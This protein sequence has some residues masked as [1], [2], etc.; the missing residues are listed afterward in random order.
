MLSTTET[1]TDD[2]KHEH[3]DGGDSASV[4]VEDEVL[5]FIDLIEADT[6]TRGSNILYIDSQHDVIDLADIGHTNN[7]ETGHSTEEED[8]QYDGLNI[9]ESDNIGLVQETNM[10]EVNHENMASDAVNPGTR[11]HTN[12]SEEVDYTDSELGQS[13]SL[14]METN[15]D[16]LEEQAAYDVIEVDREFKE[17]D[18]I[19]HKKE[20]HFKD[21]AS[22]VGETGKDTPA[23]A[24][25][26]VDI[27]E[28]WLVAKE[29]FN[30][31]DFFYMF[32][33]GLLPT[34]WDVHTDMWMG[35]E[36]TRKG[37]LF[38]AGT[39][40]F[41]VNLPM[42]ALMR[43]MLEKC[44]SKRG[45]L[46]TL[47]WWISVCGVCTLLFYSPLFFKYS[48]IFYSICLLSMKAVAV[49]LHT[50]AVKRL[51]MSLSEAECQFESSMQLLFII[52]VW[53]RGGDLYLSTIVSSVILIGKVKSENFLING[54]AGNLLAGQTCLAKLSLV[55]RY[56]P[57]MCLTAVFRVGAGALITVHFEHVLPLSTEMTLA[58]MLVYNVLYVCLF[59]VLF[60]CLKAIH[61]P[62]RLLS[63][64]EL[65]QDRD[66]KTGHSREGKC[67]LGKLKISSIVKIWQQKH[68]GKT[69][70]NYLN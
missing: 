44:F 59:L 56:M 28:M 29:S 13:A 67:K 45:W 46:V 18:L 24:T 7:V 63:M 8:V 2:N 42:I 26:P 64:E 62:L 40:Y 5:A 32:I 33:L 34:A 10:R 48:A 61:P 35:E 43:D 4:D 58:I 16:S 55:G 53:C 1:A 17:T 12:V 47:A 19:S 30:W 60:Y 54:P 65:H 70:S 31:S 49:F 68:C 66:G 57:V 41:F 51:S 52:N 37:D 21:E 50:P 20:V 9:E 15:T 39:C 36:F 23:S 69:S 38:L 27:I 11:S 6:E 3:G 25:G 22:E 14:N